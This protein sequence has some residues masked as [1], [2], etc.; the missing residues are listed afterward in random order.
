MKRKI[1]SAVLVLCACVAMVFAAKQQEDPCTTKHK[2]CTT[3]CESEYRKCR[4]RQ[5]EEEECQRRKQACTTKCDKDKKECEEKSGGGKG[6]K[7][8]ATPGKK[9]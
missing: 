9:K 2:E 1:T 3:A 8:T 7:A 4:A 5:T 6:P